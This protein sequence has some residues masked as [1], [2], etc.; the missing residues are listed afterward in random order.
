[1]TGRRRAGLGPPEGAG[2][3]HAETD[4]CR[5]HRIPRDTAARGLK[6]EGNRRLSPSE[7]TEAPWWTT[8]GPVER[9]NIVPGLPE[10]D[11]TQRRRSSDFPHVILRL[12]SPMC[13]VYSQS[14]PQL[15]PQVVRSTGHAHLR[16]KSISIRLVSIGLPQPILHHSPSGC[17]A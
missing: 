9:L 6:S 12:L 1:M 2:E 5:R 16:L 14:A 8:P 13:A 11:R 4:T 10:R 15:R 3:R 7:T 17:S